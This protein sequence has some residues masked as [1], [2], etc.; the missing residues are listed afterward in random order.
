V[1]PEHWEFLR[2][3]CPDPL[4]CWLLR[5]AMPAGDAGGQYAGLTFTLKARPGRELLAWSGSSRLPCR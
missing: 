2:D 4:R 1:P 5:L 3:A